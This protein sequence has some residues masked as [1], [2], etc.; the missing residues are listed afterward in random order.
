[1]VL[2]GLDF[3][4]L[5]AGCLLGDGD[6]LAGFYLEESRFGIHTFR[7]LVL[8]HREDR[9]RQGAVLLVFLVLFF[10]QDYGDLTPFQ[11]LI[12]SRKHQFLRVELLFS[13]SVDH[14]VALLE[15]AAVLAEEVSQILLTLDLLTALNSLVDLA[16]QLRAVV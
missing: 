15:E 9:S 16:D 14:L 13:H 12:A 1:M 10:S 5:V 3:R 11:H 8:H 2:R 4:V 6:V 7:H